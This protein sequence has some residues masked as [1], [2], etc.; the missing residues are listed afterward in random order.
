MNELSHILQPWLIEHGYKAVSGAGR[1]FIEIDDGGRISVGWV[2][3]SH[4]EVGT[5]L[6]RFANKLDTWYGSPYIVLKPAE[7]EFFPKLLKALENAVKIVN[8]FEL[9]KARQDAQEAV[10]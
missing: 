3:T 10:R 6:Q 7:P 2:S 5:G 8:D 9:E 1:D 4:V